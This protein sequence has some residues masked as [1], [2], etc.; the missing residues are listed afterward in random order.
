MEAFALAALPGTM[1][2]SLISGLSS[3]GSFLSGAA[4]FLSAGTAALQFGQQ[5]GAADLSKL[6]GNIAAQQEELAATQREADRKERLATA[7]ASQAASAG[8]RGVFA[9][10]GSP[11]TVLQEDV[12]REEQAT[13]TDQFN[14]RLQAMTKRARGR[15]QAGTI[16]AGANIGL[17]TSLA[18]VAQTL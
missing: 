4:P 13:S 14:A 15:N 18:D 5:R 16:K 2:G 10:E 17:A 11:L 3:A 1:S 8:A 7:M 6:E 12:R 9:F